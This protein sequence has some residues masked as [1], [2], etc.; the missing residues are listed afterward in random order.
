MFEWLEDELKKIK[1]PKFHLI[2]GV[3]SEERQKLV[4][5]SKL[6]VPLSYKKFVIEY[7]N[8]KLYR[9][10][11]LYLVRIYSVPRDFKDSNGIDYLNFGRTDLSFAYFKIDDLF[12]N[13]EKSV[14]EWYA[15]RNTII[16]TSD[17][18]EEWIHKKSIA[19]KKRYKKSVWKQ[20]IAGPKPFTEKENQ[21]VNARKLFKWRIVGEAGNGNI[22]FEVHNCSLLVLPYLTI[23]IRGK[24]N[25]FNGAVWLS[26][27]HIKPGEKALIEKD[28][29][30]NR[31]K[32]DE[33]E[34]Y[35]KPD[36]GPEDRSVYWEFL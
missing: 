7:G 25:D 18:F 16:K 12:I 26:V 3:L 19:A 10:G 28:C 14:Y 22:I 27:S 23:G 20:I 32:L 1:T 33:I 31:F 29:Y 9:Q 24:N 15:K 5:Q 13:S 6:S 30:K 17:G 34:I 36:P 8:V 11:N 21:I 2:D 35:T 4:M